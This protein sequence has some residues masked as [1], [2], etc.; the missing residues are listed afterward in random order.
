MGAF[1]CG[2]GALREMKMG[3]ILS[4]ADGKMALTINFGD[5]AYVVFGACMPADR[6]TP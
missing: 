6:T 1:E 3:Q 5:A 2:L 4:E